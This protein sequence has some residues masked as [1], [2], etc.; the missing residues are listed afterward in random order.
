[1]RRLVFSPI[2]F[3]PYTMSVKV[4]KADV[5]MGKWFSVAQDGL[6]KDEALFLSGGF[7]K[8]TIVFGDIQACFIYCGD[9]TNNVFDTRLRTCRPFRLPWPMNWCTWMTWIFPPKLVV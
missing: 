7:C 3:K 4:A 2:R 9:D 1:M 5:N 6:A 8:N